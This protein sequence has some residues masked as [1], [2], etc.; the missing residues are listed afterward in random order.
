M[1]T[2]PSLLSFF[3]KS[4]SEPSGSWFHDDECDDVPSTLIVDGIEPLANQSLTN[5]E[6]N[7]PLEDNEV[8]Y[9]CS[10]KLTMSDSEDLDWSVNNH[11]NDKNGIGSEEMF[12][13]SES[14][15]ESS[16]QNINMSS[17]DTTDSNINGL[18][19]NKESTN[20]NTND[21]EMENN[22]SVSNINSNIAPVVAKEN[23]VKTPLSKFSWTP[24]LPSSSSCKKA[25]SATDSFLSSL[26][27]K[28]SQCDVQKNIL[29]KQSSD[30]FLYE[31]DSSNFQEGALLNGNDGDLEVVFDATDIMNKKSFE[32][33]SSLTSDEKD[34]SLKLI[35][36]EDYNNDE[37]TCKKKSKHINFNLEV[38][39]QSI[40]SL[41]KKSADHKLVRKFRAQISPNDN[42]AA[43]DELRR[44]ISKD[45]FAKVHILVYSTLNPW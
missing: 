6:E 44:E 20:C 12:S 25:H 41:E 26:K 17:T 5:I 33:C 3:K 11:T 16:I 28:K 18:S 27:A 38:L 19:L 13:N 42:T 32:K 34:T 36:C 40:K 4:K 30:I 35:M 39:K 9:Q 37:V 22:M 43:E 29:K 1:L 23:G 10:E 24:A 8:Q 14:I 7:Q 15:E 45:M 2:E 21:M 31:N